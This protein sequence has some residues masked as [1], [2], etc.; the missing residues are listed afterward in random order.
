[1]W[2]KMRE[3]GIPYPSITDAEMAELFSFIY[4]IRYVDEPG[5]PKEG[6]A[7]LSNRGCT[8][9]HSILGKGGTIGPDLTRWGVYVNPIVWAQQMWEHAPQMQKAM[10]K[11]GMSWPN[12]NAMDLINLV[13]YI[14]SI[15]GKIQE[16]HHL[17]PGSPERGR[18]LFSQKGCRECHMV[19]GQ[20]QHE[21]PDFGRIEFPRTLAGMAAL[22]W[23]HSPDMMEMMKVRNVPRK[24]IQPQ[25]MADILSYLFAYRYFDPPGD[26]SQGKTVFEDK[27]CVICHTI[28]AGGRDGSI[29]P[30]LGRLQSITTIKVTQSI[31]NH[32]P[33]MMQKMRDYGFSWPV[34]KGTDINDMVAYLQSVN[35]QAK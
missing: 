21:A 28:G 29:G 19:E 3:E 7:L 27:N 15:G 6:K 25:E 26:P 1:M 31:W 18:E 16:E 30:N 10:K 17:N 11:Q 35:L 32:G 5:D 24:A 22:M 4:F 14:Q 20:G 8:R 13:A 9:C 2:E 12:L 23:N 33:Q 34:L